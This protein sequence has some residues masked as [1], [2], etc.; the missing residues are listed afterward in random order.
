MVVSHSL[1]EVD[2]FINVLP[3]CYVKYIS[4]QIRSVFRLKF[5][6]SETH[7]NLSTFDLYLTLIILVLLCQPVI[8]DRSTWILFIKSIAYIPQVHCSV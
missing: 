7:Y 2:E 3:Y 4:D 6:R 5:C 1:F 8:R